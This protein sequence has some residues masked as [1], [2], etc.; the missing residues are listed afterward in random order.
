MRLSL[1]VSPPYVALSF[2][3]LPKP[4]ASSFFLHV[5]QPNFMDPIF[6][7]A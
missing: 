1:L 3:K 7:C 5:A 2:T 4:E 6:Q